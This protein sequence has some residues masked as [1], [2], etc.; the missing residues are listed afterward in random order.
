[1]RTDKR[2]RA[3]IEY[4]N[5]RIVVIHRIKEG[6]EYF[7]FPGGGVEEG[8][9]PL[10]AVIREGIEELG[11][12]LIPLKLLYEEDKQYYYLCRIVEGELGT[13]K[14]KEFDD[15]AHGK[16]KIELVYLNKISKM[17]LLPKSIRDNVVRDF[18]NGFSD[19]CS[20]NEK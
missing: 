5:D 9:T 11:V 15:P 17:E 3:I 16:Y 4:D 18:G 10:E 19:Y 20:R 12:R 13:G 14:A 8:E 2:S 1:M 6:R 7:V